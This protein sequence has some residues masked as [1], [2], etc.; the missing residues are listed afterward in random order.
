VLSAGGAA[1]AAPLRSVPVSRVGFPTAYQVSAIATD[2]VNGDGIAD[3]TACAAGT[4]FVIARDG[5]TFAPA[6][7]G[8]AVNCAAAAAGDRDGDGAIDIAVVSYGSP[9]TLTV[10]SP[11]NLDPSA[12]VALPSTGSG[13]DVAIGNV[14]NDPG[15]EIVATTSSGTYIY[16]GA[17]LALKWSFSGYNGTQVKLGDVDGDGRKDIVVNGGTGYVLDGQTHGL[18]FGYVGGFG[19][20]MAV[21]DVDGDQKS[22][23]VFSQQ[24]SSNLTILNGDTQTIYTIPGSGNSIYSVAIGDINGDGAPEILTGGYSIEARRPSDGLLLWSYTSTYGYGTT[25]AIALADF[26]GSGTIDVVSTTNNLF[27][28]VDASDKTVVWTN[29]PS[30]GITTAVGDLDGD[31]RLEKVVATVGS[32]VVQIYDLQTGIFEA[33][34]ATTFQNGFSIDRIAIGQVDSDPQQEII[35]IG[36]Q[37]YY[38]KSIATWDGVTHQVEYISPPVGCCPSVGL[39]SSVLIAANVDNDPMDEI[40]IAQSDSKLLVFNGTSNFAQNIV[41][42]SGSILDAA[43]TDLNGDNKPELVIG[44]SSNLYVF[45]TTTWT[46]MGSVALSAYNLRLA[47]TSANGGLVA[48]ISDGYSFR[49]FSTTALTPAWTCSN[50]P[51]TTLAYATINGATTLIAGDDYGSLREYDASSMTCPAPVTT[52]PYASN[53]RKL[54]A[55]DVTAD[56]RTDLLIDF[57]QTSE[58]RLIG[59]AE[60]VNGDVTQDGLV[61]AADVD[62]VTDWLLKGP[63]G[64]APGADVNRD[65]VIDI[66]DAL[67]LVNYQYSGGSLPQ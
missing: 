45:D 43:V 25:S 5:G 22:E 26:D 31:G 20:S 34:L 66:R 10:F 16:D 37:G 8:S 9:G 49:T 52:K 40:L 41:P 48:V 65:H 58:L 11:P 63:P 4:P 59:K 51:V 35:A 2:D 28:I 55:R 61:N 60:D 39:T 13:S 15:M 23:I 30:S 17:T 50:S 62:A 33:S 42:V 67:I 56:G 27:T 7:T 53:I 19:V 29:P 12:S 57:V 14:D 64:I 54:E 38:G 21:G 1:S 6:W 24:Y 46:A 36:G 3:I 18:L 32:P 44:T 47:A